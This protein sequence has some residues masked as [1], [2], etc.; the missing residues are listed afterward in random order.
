MTTE[1]PPAPRGLVPVGTAALLAGFA[2]LV[3]THRRRLSMR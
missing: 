3:V 1:V 2:L